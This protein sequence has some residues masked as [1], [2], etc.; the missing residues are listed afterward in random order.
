MY[1]LNLLHT[2]ALKISCDNALQAAVA[3]FRQAA[4]A[5]ITLL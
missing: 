1:L 2:Y 5:A 4:E 3:L